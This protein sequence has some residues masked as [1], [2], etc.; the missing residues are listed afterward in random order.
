MLNRRDVLLDKL[1]EETLGVHLF[2]VAV[3]VALLQ[4]VVEEVGGWEGI[5]E[6]I[7]VGGEE[8]FGTGDDEEEGERDELEEVL[9]DFGDFGEHEGCLLLSE[10]VVDHK[11]GFEG[12]VLAALRMVEKRTW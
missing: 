2:P 11:L 10:H 12:L 5:G 8:K 9:S 3:D 1:E 7:E 6:Q 4:L